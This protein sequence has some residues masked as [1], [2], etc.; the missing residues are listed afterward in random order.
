MLCM[1]MT[2]PAAVAAVQAQ[3]PNYIRRMPAPVYSDGS[4]DMYEQAAS[5]GCAQQRLVP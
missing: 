3:V 1:M 5:Q 2:L 4:S